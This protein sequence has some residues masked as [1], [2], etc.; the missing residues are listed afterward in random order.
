MFVISP[1]TMGTRAG[2]GGSSEWR[3]ALWPSL[4]SRRGGRTTDSVL[5]LPR[6]RRSGLQ[7]LVP[8]G[9]SLCG[10]AGWCPWEDGAILVDL[11]PLPAP[12]SP[13]GP[14]RN[15]EH[16]TPPHM[17]LAATQHPTPPLGESSS[18]HETQVANCFRCSE[19][20]GCC[21]PTCLRPCPGAGSAFISAVLASQ[22][23]S[24]AVP[25]DEKLGQVGEREVCLHLP[26]CPTPPPT[27]I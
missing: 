3:P 5:T 26:S 15:S 12:A 23:L 8:L 13:H 7:L 22:Q 4:R 11:E 25:L 17:A 24:P 9:H 21:P 6:G 16:P 18:F 2:G 1:L 14:G 19:A 10:V 20:I 27:G